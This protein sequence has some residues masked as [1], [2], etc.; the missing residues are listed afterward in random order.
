M[1]KTVAEADL[2]LNV[3][4]GQQIAVQALRQRQHLY[5]LRGSVYVSVIFMLQLSQDAQTFCPT[6]HWGTSVPVLACS[7]I[8]PLKE[9]EEDKMKGMVLSDI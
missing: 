9:K 1:V 7:L 4:P 6:L 8:L 3:V 2:C 5:G